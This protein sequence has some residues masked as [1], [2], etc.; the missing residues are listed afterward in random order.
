MEL[1]REH[2]RSIIFATFD[3]D[4]HGKSALKNLN[5]RL[6]IKHHPITL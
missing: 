5:L 6:A 4:F 1:T 2:L 3:V